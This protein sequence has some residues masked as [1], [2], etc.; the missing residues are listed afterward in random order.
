MR[1]PGEGKGGVRCK[2]HKSPRPEYAG[3]GGGVKAA[4]KLGRAH[5]TSATWLQVMNDQICIS[6]EDSGIWVEQNPEV[7]KWWAPAAEV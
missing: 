2:A 6:K 3:K 4:V 5:V 1:A 7:G